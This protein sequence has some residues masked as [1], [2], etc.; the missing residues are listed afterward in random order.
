MNKHLT[1]EEFY[2]SVINNDGTTFGSINV[3]SVTYCHYYNISGIPNGIRVM[4]YNGLLKPE[5]IT[6]E[7]LLNEFKLILRRN[8]LLKLKSKI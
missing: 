6:T 3:G 8:K 7:Q 2:N 4:K 1:P 5:Y